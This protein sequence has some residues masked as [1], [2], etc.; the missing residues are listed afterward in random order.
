MHYMIGL[1]GLIGFAGL[2]RLI[3]ETTGF[4]WCGL[5]GVVD[6]GW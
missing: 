2:W 1:N 5:L 3:P 4:D 6:C